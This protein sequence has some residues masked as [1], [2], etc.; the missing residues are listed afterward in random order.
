MIGC[1]VFYKGLSV[2]IGDAKATF[3]VVT[4][5]WAHWAKRCWQDIPVCDEEKSSMIHS[6]CRRK[7]DGMG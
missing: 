2:Y 7:C 4:D 5:Q 6:Y 3:L 1:M